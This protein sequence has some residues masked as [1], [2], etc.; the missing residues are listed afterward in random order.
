VQNAQ[1]SRQEEPV[2]VGPGRQLGAKPQELRKYIS[3][4]DSPDY[5]RFIVDVQ[6]TVGAPQLSESPA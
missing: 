3:M 4:E 6:S 1:Q 2:D 5:G